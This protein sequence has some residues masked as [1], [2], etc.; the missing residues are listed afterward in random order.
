MRVKFLLVM[1]LSLFLFVV[2]AQAVPTLD[3]NM[4][5]NHPATASISY[6]G[7][8]TPLIGVDIS[9]DNVIGK[10]VPLNNLV[11]LKI[12]NGDLDFTTGN[13]TGSNVNLWFFAGGGTITLKGGVDLNQ[14]NVEDAGDIPSGTTLFSGTFNNM[15]VFSSGGTFKTAVDSFT[16]NKNEDLTNFYGLPGGIPS[17]F[18]YL[19]N[20]NLSFSAAGYPP[21]ATFTSTGLDIGS[22]DIT[23]VVPEPTTLILFGSGLLGAAL[24]RRLRKPKG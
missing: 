18:F 2:P 4:D 8:A 17:N 3:F 13:L 19:G 10:G 11:T 21:P 5:A 15:S 14:N 1:L 24:Y 9:V 20:F 16:D 22:G 6:A 23:N 12:F 7:G